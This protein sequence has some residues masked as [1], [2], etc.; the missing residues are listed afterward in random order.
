MKP[1]ARATGAALLLAGLTLVPARAG[2]APAWIYRSIVLPRG[3]VAL[4]LG[5]GLGRAPIGA[6]DRSYTGTGMNLEVAGGITSELEL[7]LRT[8]VR[9]DTDGQITRA[10][11]YGRPFDTETYGTGGD[12][13][14]NPE[15]HLRWAVARGSVAQ[16]GLEA[17]AYLPFESG[18]RFGVMLGVPLTLRLGSVRFDTGVYVPIIFTDPTTTAVSIPLHI[19]IQASSTLWLG[20]ILGVRIVNDHPGSHDDYPLGFGLGSALSHAID[21]RAWFLF[22]RING[23][24]AARTFG[25][26]VGLQIRFE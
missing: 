2:A 16:V 7:G 9:F 4:D 8:G 25:A 23:D 20:P 12:R 10:D 11:G 18:T 5:L 17:R 3:D 24:R 1:L 6:T 15:L 14:A 13:M 26:G 19:W 21:L 22:P